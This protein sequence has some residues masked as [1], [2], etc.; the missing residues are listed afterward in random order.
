MMRPVYMK[1]W[2]KVFAAWSSHGIAFSTEYGKARRVLC[3][4]VVKVDRCE[5]DWDWKRMMEEK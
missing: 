3:M 5:P 4:G 2:A 1:D